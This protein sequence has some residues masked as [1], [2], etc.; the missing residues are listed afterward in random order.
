MKRHLVFPVVFACVLISGLA[1]GADPLAPFDGGGVTGLTLKTQLEKGLKARRPV[2]FE[3]IDQII[4]LV[5]DGKLSRKLVVT[6]YLKAQQEHRHPLQYFQIAL[7]ARARGLNVELPNLN[8]QTVGVTV[9]GFT[10]GINLPPF[11]T[12]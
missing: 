2:E 8:K 1:L 7:E 10:R 5:E 9:N 12:F 3:Y 11:R 6:T 4:Q